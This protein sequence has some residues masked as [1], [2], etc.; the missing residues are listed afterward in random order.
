MNSNNLNDIT[1]LQDNVFVHNG[2]ISILNKSIINYVK[3]AAEQSPLK[4]ARINF[5]HSDHD[6]VHEMIIVAHKDGII[7]PHSHPIDKPESYHVIEGVLQVSIFN[8]D[9][10]LKETF[11]LKHDEH[12]KMYRI[13]GGVWHQP[14]PV[15]EWVI[16]HEVATGPFNKEKD[17]IFLE[18]NND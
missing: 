16:Y 4:R 9:G 17:V 14:I 3:N 5:H 2:E 15:T 11:V 12:P 13:Q 6:S 10:A 7:P 1:K 8:N 18:K